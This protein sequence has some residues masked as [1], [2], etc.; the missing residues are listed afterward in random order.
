MKGLH[1]GSKSFLRL[2]CRL[3]LLQ[4]EVAN[5]SVQSAGDRKSR[6]SSAID[7]RPRERRTRF[8]AIETLHKEQQVLPCSDR[9]LLP[10]NA[11]VN[12]AEV[13]VEY[14][15]SVGRRSG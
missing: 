7:A 1:S 5:V 10:P 2:S 15:N 4:P 8:T 9:V 11:R 14:G 6:R 12:Q 3:Q 13:D